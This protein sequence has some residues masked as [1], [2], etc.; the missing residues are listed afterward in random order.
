MIVPL[1]VL[2]YNGRRLLAE[3]L[4]SVVRA[5]AESRHDCRVAVIDNDSTDDSLALLATQ[6]P[7]VSVFRCP[8]L[9]LCSY[10]QVLAELESPVAVLLNNDI[11]LDRGC[12]DPL[13]VPLDEHDAA[14]DPRC[15]MTAPLCRQFDGETY[16]GLKTAVGWRWGLVQA[17]SLYPGHEA[18][19][20]QPDFTAS[21][22]AILAVNRRVFLDLGGFD[23]LY[24][25]GR[26]E[27]LDFAFR[28]FQAGYHARYVPEAVAYHRGLGTFGEVFGQAGCDDLALRNTLLFQWKNL[29]HPAHLARQVAG[30]LTRLAADVARAPLVARER[31]WA[32]CRALGGAIG[33]LGRLRTGRRLP[34]S[35]AREREFFRRF[36]PAEL[37]ESKLSEEACL[38]LV[39]AHPGHSPSKSSEVVK[40]FGGRVS[41]PPEPSEPPTASCSLAVVEQRRGTRTRSRFRSGH[42]I[43]QSRDETFLPL[44]ASQPGHSP[45]ESRQVATPF[46]GRVSGPPACAADERRRAGAYPLSRWYLRPAAG[47]LAS[48]LASTSIRPAHLTVCGLFAAIAAAAVLLSRAELAPLAGGLVLVAWFFDRADGQLARLRNAASPWGAWLDANVDELADVGLHVATAAAAAALTAST[49]PWALLVAFLAGKYLFMHGL[50]FEEQAAGSSAGVAYDHGNPS[51][52][53]GWVR[54]LYHL[55]GNADVR[56]HLLA[57]AILCGWM[58]SELALV[59]VYYNFRWVVRYLLVARRLDGGVR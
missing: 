48:V 17:T 58:T 26:L 38:P 32:F 44:V 39:A 1:L 47:W 22:G 40:S 45:S 53:A 24:L 29:R 28:G 4:P 54:S 49:L 10:N 36:S 19:I 25:P 34:G 12:V 55:P 52:A 23:P 6:F 13:V 46:G 50:M 16:E 20:D 14:H 42:L 33:R 51:G 15:F 35:L 3:C 57:G 27:D 8:N 11:K 30:G 9:G 5:A 41:G 7:Q 43:P 37:G 59:A 18:T 2:N 21:A 31:R 56:V